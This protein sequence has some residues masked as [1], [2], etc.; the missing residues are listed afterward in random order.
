M[1]LLDTGATGTGVRADIVEALGLPPKGQRRVGTANGMIWATELPF[2]IGFVTGDHRIAPFDPE[3]QQ[4]YVLDRH[5]SGFELQ[6][7]FDYAVLVGMDVLG[8][9]DLHILRDGTA[10]LTIF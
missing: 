3:T 2:R 10:E 5:V 4:P 9:C 6:R 8:Q 1:A 7:G